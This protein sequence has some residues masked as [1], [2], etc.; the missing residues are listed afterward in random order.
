MHNIDHKSKRLK[1]EEE[2]LA[3]KKAEQDKNFTSI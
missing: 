2:E 1:T 3:R